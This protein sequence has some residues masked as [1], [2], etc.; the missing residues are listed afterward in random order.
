VTKPIRVIG[1]YQLSSWSMR[2]WLTLKAA[3]LAF[4]TRLIKLQTPGTRDEILAHSPSGKVPAL[5]HEDVTICDSM[6][7]CEYIAEL[8]TQQELWPRDRKLRALARSASAEMHSGYTNLRTQMSF[9]LN[10]VDHVDKVSSETSWEIERIFAIWRNL[11]MTSGAKTFLCG[12]FGI[13]DAMFAPVHF[14]F[15]R[16]G[17]RVPEDLQTYA[18][19]VFSF[20]AVEEWMRLAETQSNF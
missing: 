20:H 10:T 17:V 7:I 14:R 1:D 8:A 6:A 18:E 5:I 11:L 2:P 15:R 19:S 9:G 12:P 16:F 13:V 4:E 3:G